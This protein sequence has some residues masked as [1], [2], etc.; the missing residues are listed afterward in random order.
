[1]K[2]GIVVLSS[3]VLIIQVLK[4]VCLYMEP[5]ALDRPLFKPPTKKADLLSYYLV[6]I[7]GLIIIILNRLELL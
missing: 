6:A 7:F 2:Y 1:M 4:I 3:I 5:K